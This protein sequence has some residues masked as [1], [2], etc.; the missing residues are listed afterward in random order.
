MFADEASLQAA[1]LLALADLTVIP[2]RT[3]LTGSAS[4]FDIFFLAP[5]IHLQASASSLNGGEFP[6]TGAMTTGYIFRVENPATVSFLQSVGRTGHLV[7]THVTQHP[8]HNTTNYSVSRFLKGFFVAG[9]L[10]SLVY[11]TGP[12]LTI[13]AIVILVNKRDWWS[14]AMI[15]VL[16]LARLINAAVIR[17]RSGKGWKGAKEEGVEGDLL[18][19]LSQDRWL[20]MRGLV[21]DLKTVTAGQWLRDETPTESFVVGFATLLVYV[22]P[23]LGFNASNYGNVIVAALLVVNAALLALCNSTT[24]CLQMVD[25][26]VSVWGKPK[27][28]TRRLDLAKELIQSSGRDDW[29]IGLGLIVPEKPRDAVIL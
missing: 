23:A 18:I 29:A 26:V 19:L 3:A 22:A 8:Y 11:L 24:G 2:R 9:V 7:T 15:G 27:K 13:I 5:G 4:L 25:C 21:D 12:A 17:R 16:V 6:A 1:G 20:R 28:Y 10:P 14:S